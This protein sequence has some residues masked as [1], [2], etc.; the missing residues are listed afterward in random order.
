MSETIW[1]R[2][3]LFVTR[4]VG[5]VAAGADR[6][7]WQFWIPESEPAILERTDVLSLARALEDDAS[8]LEPVLLGCLLRIRQAA[9]APEIGVRYT[10]AIRSEIE[11]E[12]R[13]LED[14]VR[15]QI[16]ARREP[17]PPPA[18]ARAETRDG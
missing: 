17:R 5:P 4:F 13:R 11:Q 7:R 3:C 6:Q 15:A 8:V 18:E 1:Q 9:F 2:E 12:C 14:F 10:E 16:A